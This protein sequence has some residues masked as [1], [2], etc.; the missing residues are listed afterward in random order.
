MAHRTNDEF[1]ADRL[2]WVEETELLKKYADRPISLADACLI[3]CAELRNFI[4]T[5]GS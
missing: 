1:W 4:R 3:R 5:G 2:R